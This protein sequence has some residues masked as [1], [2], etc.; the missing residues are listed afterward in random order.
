MGERSTRSN[1]RSGQERSNLTVDEGVL[2]F[3]AYS[4]THALVYFTVCQGIFQ[5][6][7]NI[8][9]SLALN[10]KPLTNQSLQII[11]VQNINN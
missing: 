7:L 8:I 2:D 5:P 3:T 4:S 10:N 11:V 6:Q 9:H 1:M